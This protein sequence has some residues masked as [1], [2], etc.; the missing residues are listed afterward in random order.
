[1]L[2]SD[3]AVW[4]S[5]ASNAAS[6]LFPTLFSSSPGLT[7]DRCNY[8]FKFLN[9]SDP[10]GCDSCGCHG[11]GS[12]HQFCNPFSGRCECKEHV[13]GMQCDACAPGYYGLTTLGE[14][15]PCGCDAAGTAGTAP[16]GT[17]DF[18]TGQC[19][20]KAHAEGRR[21]H[22]CQPG[23]HS[24]DRTNSLGCLPCQCDPRGTVNG[25]NACH[26]D[27]A[28]CPCEERV[29]GPQCTLCVQNTFNRT[30]TAADNGSHNCAPCRCDLEGTV[31]GSVCDPVSGQ[32]V[33]LPS[34]QG[35]DCGICRPGK[36]GSPP[37]PLP[38][39]LVQ[40]VQGSQ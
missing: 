19:N 14:C 22:A 39:P 21:C 15:R 28:Q 29:E 35:Q 34:R 30:D 5:Q 6:L 27:T 10:D 40:A 17:C 8:G 1:M 18:A 3:E 12:L 16:G 2:S 33:C 13:Q 31:P 7:C 23:Y 25:S 37:T 26:P 9:Q 32:C 4:L 36:Q 11:N 20:C 24:L 38:P